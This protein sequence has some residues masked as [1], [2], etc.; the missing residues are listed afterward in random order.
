[1][2]TVLLL[3]L[4]AI[5]FT[6]DGSEDEKINPEGLPDY[7]VPP[8]IQLDPSTTPAAPSMVPEKDSETEEVVFDDFEGENEMESLWKMTRLAQTAGSSIF[9]TSNCILSIY[10]VFLL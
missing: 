6:A 1:M 5:C 9:S 10:G 8:P 2:C 7:K 4:F 3:T